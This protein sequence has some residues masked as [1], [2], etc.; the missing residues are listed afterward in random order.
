MNIL[1][2]ITYFD[3][4]ISGLTIYASRL[5]Q[6]LSDKGHIVTVLCMRHDTS[7]KERETV[8]KVNV[9]RANPFVHISKGFL[10]LDWWIQSVRL[11]QNTD[12]VV[13]NL[14]EFEGVITALIARLY[15][16]RVISIYHCEIQLSNTFMGQIIQSLLEVSNALTL[17]L[18]LEIVTYTRDYANYSRLLRLFPDKVTPIYPPVPKPKDSLTTI[19]R[20]KAKIG[21]ADVL[22]GVSARLAQEKGIEYLLEAVEDIQKK[23]KNKIVKVIVAG[24]VD[25]VGEVSYKRKIMS[26]IEQLQTNV[27]FVGS[28]SQEEIGAFYRLIDILVLPSVNS[29]EAF[30]MVQVESM[31]VGTPVIAT[32]LPGVR[33]PIRQT[34]MGIV[35]APGNA[36]AI[37]DAV[38]TI[39]NDKKHYVKDS[40]AIQ[41]EFSLS[42]VGE[43]IE[44]LLSHYA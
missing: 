40:Q 35:V 36:H 8:K 13:V 16:K 10:S 30:G 39:M 34:G 18:S 6:L 41:K 33:I 42:R 9:V 5:S 4:Y 28:L 19:K 15:N 23:M 25:P 43:R 2:T 11:V 22:L 7:L 24:P 26:L 17:S 12:V 21:N 32:D 27:V 37:A 1:L 38:V 31:L 20:L 29:T 3:P 14:P 44:D